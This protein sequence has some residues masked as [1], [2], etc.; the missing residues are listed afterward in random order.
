MDAHT[1]FKHLL[2][3][4]SGEAKCVEIRPK[5]TGSG[6]AQIIQTSTA[7]PFWGAELEFRGK[8]VGNGRARIIQTSTAQP[9]WRGRMCGEISE[10]HRKWTRPVYSHAYCIATLE[11]QNV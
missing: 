9:L 5:S 2:L 1:L 3:S 11:R 6:P 7:Q 8:V 10:V 4:Y